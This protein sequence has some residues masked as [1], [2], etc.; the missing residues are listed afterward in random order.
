MSRLGVCPRS[1]CNDY[2]KR[3][4]ICDPFCGEC[5]TRRVRI[6]QC[7]TDE[8]IKDTGYCQCCGQKKADPRLL[9]DAP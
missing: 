1:S 8:M 3:F 6:V 7:C 4:F 5:G 9:E 2:K